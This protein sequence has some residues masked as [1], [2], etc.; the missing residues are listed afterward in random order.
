VTD[1]QDNPTT[2]PVPAAQLR[3][4]AGPSPLDDRTAQL[5]DALRQLSTLLLLTAEAVDNAVSALTGQ[6]TNTAADMYPDSQPD[7]VPYTEPVRTGHRTDTTPD[8]RP[9]DERPRLSVVRP[10]SP[11]TTEDS[12]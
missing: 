12:Q 1:R 8:T 4:G 11:D 3:G 9:D 7:S 10:L 6:P 2:G 5:A